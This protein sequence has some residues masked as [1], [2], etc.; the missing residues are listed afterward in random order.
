[1]GADHIIVT[2]HRLLSLA[3][4]VFFAIVVVYGRVSYFRLRARY[5]SGAPRLLTPDEVDHVRRWGRRDIVGFIVTM[6]YL[7]LFS[8][9][10]GFRM[11]APPLLVAGEIVLVGLV[12][13]LLV[14][15]FAVRCPVCARSLG[16]QSGL[17]LPYFCEICRVPFR[18]SSA[19][20]LLA[21]HLAQRGHGS[22]YTSA[23]T[24]L[25]LPLVAVAIGPDPAS[26]QARGVAKGILAVGDVAIGGLAVGGTACGIVSVGGL[27]AGLLSVGGL[28]LGLIALGGA[29]LGGLACGGVAIGIGSLGGLAIGLYSHGGLSI[30]LHPRGGATIPILRP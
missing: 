17:G 23:R 10:G 14:H 15:H 2:I 4:S 12:V 27:S 9:V 13:A 21:H 11:L 30:G 3:G 5:P 6:A 24:L 18:P 8:L 26:G 29:A 22:R 16:V 19:Y 7:V 28:S 20:T 1:M 25:G